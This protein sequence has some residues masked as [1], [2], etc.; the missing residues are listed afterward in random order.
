LFARPEAFT[1]DQP[2]RLYSDAPFPVKMQL[3]RNDGTGSALLQLTFSGYLVD[4]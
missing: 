2:L 3:Q 4:L 1:I